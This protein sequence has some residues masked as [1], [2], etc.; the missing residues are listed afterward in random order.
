ML[1][2]DLQD[3]NKT[4]GGVVVVDGGKAPLVL[5]ETWEGSRQSHGHSLPPTVTGFHRKS[6]RLTE[7]EGWLHF[8]DEETEA[9][10]G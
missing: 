4:V 7:Q 3:Y 1:R 6:V 2:G 8:T 10:G 9:Q 5:E